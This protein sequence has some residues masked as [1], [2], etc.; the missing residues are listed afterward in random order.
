V[1][2]PLEDTAEGVLKVPFFHSN[3]DF[4]EVLFYHDGD[5]F[6][7]D[8]MK[9]GAITFHPQGIHHGPHPK[10]FSKANQR[11]HT[12][13]YAVMIDTK[14]PLSRSQVF[15]NYEDSHYWMSWKEQ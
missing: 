15:L 11:T 4:D 6:S 7:R 1:A 10:A 3:I 14:K 9:A 12:N 8:N 2:R 13:E 5:F